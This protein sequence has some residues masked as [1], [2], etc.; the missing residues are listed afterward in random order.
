MLKTGKGIPDALGEDDVYYKRAGGTITRS[1]RDFHNLY[2][3]RRII[4]GVAK[5]GETLIDLAVGKAGDMSKW[6]AAHLRFILGID[7]SRD[8][9]ENRKDG[10]CARYL[11]YKKRFNTMPCCAL[12][13]R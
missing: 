8:N 3:K 12:H 7:I 4:E 10:A 5:P 2:V 9:I 11:N 6:I 1:M 13:R